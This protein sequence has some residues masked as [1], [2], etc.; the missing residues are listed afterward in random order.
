M[1]LMMTMTMTIAEIAEYLGM[2]VATTAKFLQHAGLTRH[3]GSV[4]RE[5]LDAYLIVAGLRAC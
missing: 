3:A 4:R 5:E 2:D 1:I